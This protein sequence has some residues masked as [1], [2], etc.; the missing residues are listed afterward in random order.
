MTV[1][2]LA[3]ALP[4]A[5]IVALIAWRARA[6][7]LSGA[8]A[9]AAIG[10]IA[11]S[12]GWR[13]A[14]LLIVYF[15]SSAALSRFGAARKE[16]LTRSIIEKPGARDAWQVLANGFAFGVAAL[17]SLATPYPE[18]G[19]LALGAGALAASA[20][21]TWAT[22]IG[23]LYGGTPRSVLHWRPVPPGTSGAVSL[24]GSGGAVLGAIGIG[25]VA[26]LMGWG[27][28]IAVAAVIGGLGGA[29]V[30]SLLGATVQS[31]LWCDRC[32]VQTEREVH[33][34]GRRTQ[35]IRGMPWID[36]DLVNFLAG[37]AGGLLALFVG[38]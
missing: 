15:V 33:D 5:A 35:P 24:V 6:L 1:W 10:G 16:K 22:E 11:V 20:A 29:I 18:P 25:T 9:A 14:V 13:W 12:A 36:N 8:L 3:A 27:A 23:I 4:I 37:I 32:G 34:C 7:T 21:D 19:W 17:G 2:R 30:D 28:R 38:R 26:L 31:R